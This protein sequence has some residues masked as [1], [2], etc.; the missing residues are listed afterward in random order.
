VADL[1]VDSVARIV[2]KRPGAVRA[3]QHRALKRLAEVF[4]AEP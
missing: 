4:P 3:L 1:D 2:R